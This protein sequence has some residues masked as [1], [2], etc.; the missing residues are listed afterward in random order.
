MRGLAARRCSCEAC[1]RRES[2]ESSE[3][4][5]KRADRGSSPS[6]A[7][8][9]PSLF[10]RFG[11]QYNETLAILSDRSR[12]HEVLGASL[13]MEALITRGCISI[14]KGATR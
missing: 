3:P 14:S 6:P 4:A 5:D 11:A 8:D 10:E 13:R 7:H 12:H 1:V 2:G 9:H